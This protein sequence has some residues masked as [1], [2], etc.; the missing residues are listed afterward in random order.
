MAEIQLITLFLVLVLI[1]S[2]LP[3]RRK[4]LAISF[5]F[6]MALAFVIQ[7]SSV[8]LTGNIADYRFYENFN[9]SDV[10]S[11]SEFFGK[12]GV[13]LGLA[14]ILATIIINL[15]G[16]LVRKKFTGKVIPAVLILI[17]IIVLSLQGGIVNQA[18][19]TLQLKFAGNASFDEALASLNVDKNDY[20]EKDRIRAVKG[21]NIIV[22]SLESLEKG[23]LDGK[24]KHLTPNLS[25]MADSYSLYTME[26]SPAGGWTS[27]SMYLAITGVP[28]FFGSQGNSVFQNSYENKL[29]TLPDVLKKAG[30]DLQYFIGKKEYSGI[31]DLLKTHGFTVKS[32]KDFQE[33]YKEVPW[34]IQDMDLFKE[35]KK[36]LRLKNGQAKPFALFLSTISTHFPNGV[37]DTRIDSL[38]PP[39]PTRLE[40]MVAA[41]DYFVGD[42]I[43]FLKKEDLLSNTVFYIYPDHLL[44][45]TQSRVLEDFDERAL[46]VLTNADPEETQYP[47]DK[48]INQIDLAKLILNG[49]GIQHNAKF[50]TDFIKGEDKN[51]FLRKNNKNLLRL[52]DAALKTLN[53]KEGIYLSLDE[54]AKSFVIKNDED[55]IV[56]TSPLPDLGSFQRVLFDKNLRPFNNFQLDGDKQTSPSGAFV[57][58]DVF[59]TNGF[60]YGSLKGEASFGI[61]KKDKN[62][63]IFSPEDLQLLMNIRLNV[64]KHNFIE[65]KSN[66]WQAKKASGFIIKG[67]KETLS[68]G[69]TIISFYNGSDYEYKTFDTYGSVEAAEAFINTLKTLNHD[70]TKYIV[71]AHDSAA[72]SLQPYS[73]ILKEQG[74]TGLSELLDRQAYLMHNLNGSTIELVDDESLKLQLP[75]P[76]DISNVKRYFKESK[77]T[78]EPKVDRYIAHAGGEINGIKYTNSIEALNYSYQKGFRLFELDIVVT[79]DGE[80]VATHDWE[81][82]KKE[83]NYQGTVPVTLAEFR[84]HKIRGTYG[85]LDMDHIN[86]WFAAHADAILVTDKVNTPLKFAEGFVDKKRLWMELF[87]LDAVAEAVANSISP[88]PS[89]NVISQINGDTI[90]YLKQ[91][92]I[93]QIALSRR[94]IVTHTDLLKRC[95][96]NN[97]RVYVY[98]LNFDP[99]KN[100]K[101]VLENEIGLVFGM[102]ADQWLSQ[103]LP[104]EASAP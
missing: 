74:L 38:L 7:L 92:G 21:K 33:K 56:L 12:E 36:E 11:V 70:S 81:Y 67:T 52:N 102:Y 90:A 78:F 80:F 10:L 88:I 6:F 58:L 20:Y 85:T 3:F 22:L 5:S 91:N 69:L 43:D 86:K 39:Q 79:S 62:E 83:V 77:I 23:Y 13:L 30:Y 68:R 28:A 66:S 8:L 73:E 100:E 29:T 37:P 53:C 45:G 97:I 55:L 16:R 15:L 46:Y 93:K 72:K 14:L 94:N 35:F 51:A 26:Q 24:L 48:E 18:Y 9:I 27:A 41:T 103:F 4:A 42:L 40:Q 65:V 63:V 19:A 31:D 47:L 96:E 50:L 54:E 84:K 32:E 101:Y 25:K 34:G 75:F 44:M 76:Q 82:W 17:G 57:Y 61:T 59:V 1:R 95:R 87:S 60:L 89:E 64:D 2:L 71:L 104:D 98:H 49:A 99:G